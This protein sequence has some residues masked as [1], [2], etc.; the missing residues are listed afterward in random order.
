M[1]VGMAFVIY[2]E[3][4]IYFPVTYDGREW[5]DAVPRNPNPDWE[6]KHFGG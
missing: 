6:P 3:N 5:V 2:T 4:W 1:L